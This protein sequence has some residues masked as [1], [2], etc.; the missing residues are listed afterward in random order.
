MNEYERWYSYLYENEDVLINHLNIH[1][2]NE[3]KKKEYEIV[4]KKNILLYLSEYN[5]NFD[6]EHLKYIHKFLFED[7]YPFAGEFR[8]VNMGKGNRA[9]FTDYERIEENLHD[10]LNNIDDKLVGNSNSKFFYAEALAD[11]YYLLYQ[12]LLKII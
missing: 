8:I 3:L 7:I 4:A 2:K 5:G 10:I 6:I 12:I 9:G 1:D 11:M